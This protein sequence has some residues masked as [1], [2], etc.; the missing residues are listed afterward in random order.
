MNSLNTY[1]KGVMHRGVFLPYVVFGD[2]EF[3]AFSCESI[4]ILYI[5]TLNSIKRRVYVD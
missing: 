1:R 4:D 3:I 5:D 2:I